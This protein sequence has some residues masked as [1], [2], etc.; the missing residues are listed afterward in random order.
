MRVSSTSQGVIIMLRHSMVAVGA[1]LLAGAAAS[2]GVL[3]ETFDGTNTGY[4]PNGFT[5]STGLSFFGVG[6]F[7]STNLR[8]GGSAPIFVT[9]L[10]QPIGPLDGN[11]VAGFYGTALVVDFS[12]YQV[13]GFSFG[14]GTGYIFGSPAPRG[15]NSSQNNV[16][17]VLL[18]DDFSLISQ[19]T[20]SGEDTGQSGFTGQAILSATENIAFAAILF[21]PDGSIPRGDFGWFADNFVATLNTIP[22]PVAAL[23]AIPGL[24]GVTAIR[25]RRAV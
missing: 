24:L 6:L 23:A 3:D 8:G 12:A 7:P 16:S 19:Q 22:N 17:V 18:R 20:F 14:W 9:N 1:L 25:R 21:G 13:Q 5:G 2:G 11:V 10:E 4:Y 15:G